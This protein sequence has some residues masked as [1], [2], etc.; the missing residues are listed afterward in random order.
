MRRSTY[1]LG[2]IALAGLAGGAGLLSGASS[3]PAPGVSEASW[4]KYRVVA[5]R[6]IFLRA[7]SHPPVPRAAGA[8][9][10]VGRAE[11]ASGLVLTGVG[12]SGAIRVAV[13]EDLRS[14]KIIQAVAGEIIDGGRLVDVGMDGIVYE[15]RGVTAIPRRPAS[16]RRGARAFPPA[17]PP[18]AERR[19]D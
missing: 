16:R 8:V 3:A 6:N 12:Q 19:R 11:P 5:T 4:D 1:L 15:R 13:L 10:P 9:K 17:G 7:R 14:E 2:L 18:R